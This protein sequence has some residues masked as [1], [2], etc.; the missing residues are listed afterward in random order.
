MRLVQIGFIFARMVEP[1]RPAAGEERAGGGEKDEEEEAGCHGG[2]ITFNIEHS[3]SNISHPVELQ[4]VFHRGTRTPNIQHRTSNIL[5]T[6]GETCL[7]GGGWPLWRGGGVARAAP[8]PR[9]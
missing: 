5:D 2:R 6:A 3:T 8:L 7:A 9:P 4:P 1:Q